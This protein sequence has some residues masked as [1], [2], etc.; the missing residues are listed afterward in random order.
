MSMGETIYVCLMALVSATVAR[1]KQSSL[2][3]NDAP[4]RPQLRKPHPIWTTTAIAVVPAA[5]EVVAIRR[6]PNQAA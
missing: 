1:P 2:S 6:P 4:R 3:S 5:D